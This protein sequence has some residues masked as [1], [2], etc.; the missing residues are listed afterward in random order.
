M[1]QDNI[2]SP[3]AYQTATVLC[4]LFCSSLQCPSMGE[5]FFWGG[6]VW[7]VWFSRNSGLLLLYSWVLS[8]AIWL[9]IKLST[10]V[11]HYSGTPSTQKLSLSLSIKLRLTYK[12]Q[13][14]YPKK[15]GVSD[16]QVFYLYSRWQEFCIDPC[17]LSAILPK[18]IEI[19]FPLWKFMKLL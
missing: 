11:H 16:L 7:H 9:S 8:S 19:I 6:S 4:F 14:K 1:H 5:C 3:K 15:W 10:Q 17:N 18:Q 12:T 13:Q 2:P